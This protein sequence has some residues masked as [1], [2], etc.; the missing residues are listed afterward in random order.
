MG[1]GTDGVVEA[2]DNLFFGPHVYKC[3]LTPGNLDNEVTALTCARSQHVVQC[4]G[5]CSDP[6]NYPN[7]IGVIMER[8]QKTLHDVLNDPTCLG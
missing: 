1:A 6:I 2:A 3:G 4:M 8:M 7:R 5:R